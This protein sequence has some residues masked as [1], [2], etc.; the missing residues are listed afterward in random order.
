MKKLVTLLF[1]F[2]LCLVRA[3]AQIGQPKPW[4]AI[5]QMAADETR[6]IKGEKHKTIVVTYCAYLLSKSTLRSGVKVVLKK[7]DSKTG[8]TI[9][10]NVFM[11]GTASASNNQQFLIKENEELECS[12]QVAVQYYFSGYIYDVAQ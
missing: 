6:V 9:E 7:K 8:E 10:W 2:T 11:T 5:F 3:T 1:I 4:D 12:A